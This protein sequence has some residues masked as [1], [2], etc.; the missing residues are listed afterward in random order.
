MSKSNEIELKFA[1]NELKFIRIEFV[2]SELKLIEIAIN[3]KP[4]A[5]N[6]LVFGIN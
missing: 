2:R 3:I 4:I 6:V 1:K 5:F